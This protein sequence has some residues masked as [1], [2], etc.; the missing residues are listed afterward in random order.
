M[1]QNRGFS[2]RA[3]EYLEIVYVTLL[4][5]FFLR[6]NVRTLGTVVVKGGESFAAAVNAGERVQVFDG[7]RVRRIW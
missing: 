3:E 1:A 5:T 2:E 7:S 4:A 6:A